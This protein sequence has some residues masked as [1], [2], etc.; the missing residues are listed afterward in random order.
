MG[1]AK[2]AFREI[3]NCIWYAN[4]EQWI[5]PWCAR[6]VSE[7]GLANEVTRT[8]AIYFWKLFLR[9]HSDSDDAV[10]ELFQCEIAIFE[11]GENEN[12]DELMR[13]AAIIQG[14]SS[15]EM[16]AL[17]WAAVAL[18]ASKVSD[19]AAHEEC[20]RLAFQLEP[21]TYRNQYVDSLRESGKTNE[22]NRIDRQ[23]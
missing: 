6:L 20:L 1:E 4:D 16:A 7:F 23:S 15:D 19:S 3:Y 17:T 13:L 2:G 21:E 9:H 14:F 10:F 18:C 22:A 8:H 11:V 5:W 12:I